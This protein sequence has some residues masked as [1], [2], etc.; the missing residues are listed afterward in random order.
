MKI[1]YISG[2][3]KNTG[4][5]KY[6]K[7]EIKEWLTSQVVEAETKT[8]EKIRLYKSEYVEIKK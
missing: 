8:G 3:N 6:S 1:L 5:P 2:Y 7:A 4:A